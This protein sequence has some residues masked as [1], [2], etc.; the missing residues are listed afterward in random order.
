MVGLNEAKERVRKFDLERNF[1]LVSV[2]QTFTHIVEELGELGRHLLFIEGY[3]NS[4]TVHK[5]PRHELSLE[6]ADVIILLMKLAAQVGVDVDKAF[7]DKIMQNE[8]SFTAEKARKWT[9]NY[10]RI[11]EKSLEERKKK[12]ANL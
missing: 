12:R 2:T 7:E 10:F 1:H 11:Q 9:E 6:I 8:A 4:E 3:K 5:E